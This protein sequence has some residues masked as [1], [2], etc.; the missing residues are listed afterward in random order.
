MREKEFEYQPEKY[1]FEKASN[2]YLI[3]L[4]ILVLVLPLPIINLFG[5]IIFYTTNRRSTPFVRWHCTQVILSQI[6]LL[7]IN[8]LMIFWTLMLNLL[9]P[10]SPFYY[11]CLI[12]VILFNIIELIATVVTI[13]LLNN[14]KHVRWLFF[15]NITDYFFKNKMQK[16]EELFW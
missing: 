7:V 10:I 6:F 8:N 1:E 13:I 12:I 11:T 14:E 15:S 4:F 3:S 2:A 5:S 16:K 9:V